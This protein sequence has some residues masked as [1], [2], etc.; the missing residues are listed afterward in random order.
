M[1]REVE[2]APAPGT[3]SIALRMLVDRNSI[4]IFADA[5]AVALAFSFLPRAA[6]TSPRLSATGGTARIAS[7]SVSELASIHA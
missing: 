2:L 6:H 5:G 7:L 4:E 1:D 3:G